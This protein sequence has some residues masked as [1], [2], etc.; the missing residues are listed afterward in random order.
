VG[1][2]GWV[3]ATRLISV[4]DAAVIAA[5]VQQNRDFLAP[6]EPARDESYFTVEGQRERIGAAI[7]RARRGEALPRVILDDHGVIQGRVNLNNIIHGT[8]QSCSL[9]YW[10]AESANGRGLATMAVAEIKRIA[11]GALGLHRI[12]AGTLKHNSRSQ[13]VLERNGF[14]RFGLAPE[15]LKIDG[16]WQDHIMFQVINQSLRG[17]VELLQFVAFAPMYG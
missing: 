8:F 17:A 15:Y 7:E 9:G 3:T 5:L 14:E 11:F 16:R 2:S 1:H 12:E 6:W 10:L 13:R 4:D